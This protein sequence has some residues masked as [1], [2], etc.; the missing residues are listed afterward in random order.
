M[1]DNKPMVGDEGGSETFLKRLAGQLACAAENRLRV[2]YLHMFHRS[3][4]DFF[5]MLYI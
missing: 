1:A 4:Q 5:E 2:L 3:S